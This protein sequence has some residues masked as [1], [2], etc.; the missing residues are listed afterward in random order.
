M[1]KK[2]FRKKPLSLIL[3]DA[4]TGY[5]DTSSH[6]TLKRDLSVKDLTAMGIAAVVGAGI[7]STIGEAAYNGGPGVT[8]LFVITGVT[9]GFSAL[10]YAEFASRIPVSGSAYTYSYASFGELVAWII[11]WDLIMEYAIGNIAV[12][13]AALGVFGTGQAWPDLLVAGIM[14]GLAIWGSAEVF[15][16]ARRELAHG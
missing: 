12:L 8:I 16:Q 2:L 7:F 11:G 1:N 3:Q 9:C 13:A 14:A 5:G 10:C 15:S 4:R 6:G